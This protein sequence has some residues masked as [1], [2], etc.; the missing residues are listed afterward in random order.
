MYSPAAGTGGG[1]SGAVSSIATSTG[2]GMSRHDS[3]PIRSSRNADTSRPIATSGIASS[4]PA[5]PN[6]SP[7]DRS[8]KITT[9][10][11][12][13]TA[14]PISL[15]TMMWPSTWWMNRNRIATAITAVPDWVAATAAGASAPSHGP[16]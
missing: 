14:P 9:S 16:T 3:S 5:R 12:T 6:S 11:C 1:R 7:A 4:T 13:L 8:A 15:G 10:G 2:I